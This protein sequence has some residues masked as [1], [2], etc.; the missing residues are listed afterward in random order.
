VTLLG[1]QGRGDRGVDAAGH[2]DHNSHH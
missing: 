1:E 2:G